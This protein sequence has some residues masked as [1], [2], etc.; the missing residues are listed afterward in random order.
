[1]FAEPDGRARVA[2]PGLTLALPRPDPERARL[3]GLAERAPWGQRAPQR[4]RVISFFISLIT[5][6]ALNA[7]QRTKVLPGAPEIFG[8]RGEAPWLAF[9]GVLRDEAR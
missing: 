1:M 7:R 6:G 9:G 8:D 2:E 4:S 5:T 3:S